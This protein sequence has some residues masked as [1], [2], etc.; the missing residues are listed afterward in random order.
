MLE[1]IV[2]TAQ[3]RS[4]SVQDIPIAISAFD[5]AAI[6]ANR[7]ERI[8][9]IGNLA[10]NVEIVDS[11]T[12]TTSA[13]VAIRGAS[14]INPAITWENAVGIYLDGV[15][16]GKNLGAVFDIADLERVEVLRGPQ[17]TLY[18]KNTV[19][20]AINL[21]SRKPS[22]EF[23]GSVT[24]TA[25]NEGLWA[26][27]ASVDTPEM[28]GLKGTVSVYKEERDGFADNERDPAGEFNPL[29]NP[30]SDDEFQNEDTQA[31]RVA[32]LWDATDS[33]SAAYTFDYS[34]TDNLPRF[35]QLTQVSPNSVLYSGGLQEAYLTDDD[36]RA[37][38][39]SN[40]WA[41]EEKSEVEGH[42]LDITWRGDNITLRSI[43]AYRELTWDDVIDIDG[44][45]LDLFH[46]ER[47]VDYEAFSQE[48][49]LTGS[50]DNLD[51]VL[52]VYYLDEDADVFNPITF[53]GGFGNPTLDNRYG[54]DNESVAVYGQ[55]DWR[56]AMFDERLTLSLGARWTEEDKDQ[57]IDHPYAFFTED[58]DDTF[59]NTSVSVAASWAF[60]D[61]VNAYARYAQGWKSGGFNGEAQ[62]AAEFLSGYD[63]EEVDSYEIGLKSLLLEGRLQLN[64]A[65]FYNEFDNFQ[66]S[67]FEGAAA[68]S[69][70]Y[71]V[72]EYQTEGF[73]VEA[74]ALVTEDL[75]VSLTY[76]Y[77]D[78]SVEE[79][80][81]QFD[82][83]DEDDA[84]TPYSPENSLSLGLDWNIA[85]TGYGTWG[86]NVT[87]TYLDEYVPYFDPDQNA[88]SEID[89]RSLLNARL[90]LTEI[91]VGDSGNLE[92]ALWGQNLTDED[93][94]I[95]TIPFGGVDQ[96][97]DPNGG[98][99]VGWT[100]SYFGDPQMYGV[101]VT[102]SF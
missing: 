35:G 5:Q 9:D 23:G 67:V 10:P 80:P 32:L 38:E 52:G 11:P 83:F 36:D 16:I 62:D 88:A 79:L 87:Y 93:Y 54:L 90:A 55:G 89:S 65:A 94:R 85:Q 4:Q 101:D 84:G 72:P 22:G 20:G 14:Q 43:S 26:V 40:D 76:G 69:V 86:L 17:G 29:V 81:S 31:A 75:Q 18:G 82:F 50:M 41:F 37:E 68:A 74:L 77:L 8:T 95:N 56:P 71:N 3:K 25:G 70:V 46:S 59:D 78:A 97:V 6:E 92:I 64:L 66:A 12:N 63:D 19:G 99:G 7:I 33:L 58:T 53:F 98:S 49:Q 60:T 44:T 13:T 102:Y 100:T 48:F 24:G 2:V 96:R 45:A 1:E 39:G 51:Y 73:E 57:Y 34:E 91:P 27:R 15:F 21:I 61:N 30:P 42:A 47:H 28:A